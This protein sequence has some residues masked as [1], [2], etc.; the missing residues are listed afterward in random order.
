MLSASLRPS[1]APIIDGRSFMT[2][3]VALTASFGDESQV[4]SSCVAV[5]KDRSLQDIIHA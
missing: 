5:L 2:V 4:V 1:D 3:A